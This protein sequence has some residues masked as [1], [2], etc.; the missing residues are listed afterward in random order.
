MSKDDDDQS[1][2][3]QSDNEDTD[4]DEGQ[5]GDLVE[6][7]DDNNDDEALPAELEQVLGQLPE[8]TRQ[9]IGR[10]VSLTIASS[11]DGPLPRPRDYAAYNRI[12]PGSA[13][14]IM[15]MAIKEQEI[16]EAV[17][18]GRMFNERFTI[19]VAMVGVIGLISVAIVATFLGQLVVA[20]LTAL[21]SAAILAIRAMPRRK[22]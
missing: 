3:P 4:S 15:N 17:L 18:K 14:D 22:D 16:K 7:V 6:T 2:S 20:G 8:E 13:D 19:S 12:R 5:S 11:H 1:P 10:I 9:K 21:A